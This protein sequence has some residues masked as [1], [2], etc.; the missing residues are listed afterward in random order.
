MTAVCGLQMTQ[1]LSLTLPVPQAE[2][3]KFQARQPN[4]FDRC[5][6]ARM[7]QCCYRRNV[8]SA[9]YLPFSKL[10]RQ[11]IGIFDTIK[12]GRSI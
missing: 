9:R 12:T 3:C 1:K 10:G 6:S 7:L 2:L 4:A 11:P 5:P 8:A